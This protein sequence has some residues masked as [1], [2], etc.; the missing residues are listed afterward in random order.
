[1][2]TNYHELEDIRDDAIRLRLIGYTLL[3]YM[4]IEVLA[5]SYNGTGPEFLPQRIR[6]KLDAVCRPF[7]PSV[8]I[9]DVDYTMSDGSRRSF[10]YANRRFLLNC[11]RC[12]M[13]AH[14][15]HSWRRYA[16][17]LQAWVLY[18]AVSNPRI[19]WTAWLQAY[20]KNQKKG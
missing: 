11:L 13:N 20:N 14:P 16:L 12:A 9:H 3:V 18:R 10:L 2:T 15:W 8:M 4:P 7:L 6:D 1:M 17:F 5:A 19:G